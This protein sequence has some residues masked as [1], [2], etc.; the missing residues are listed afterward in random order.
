MNN[1]Q[2][3][4]FYTTFPVPERVAGYVLD[5]DQKSVRQIDDILKLNIIIGANNSGKSLL[6][7]EMLKIK[8]QEA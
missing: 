4:E 2:L 6:L 1:F 3:H 5:G 8:N 7:R